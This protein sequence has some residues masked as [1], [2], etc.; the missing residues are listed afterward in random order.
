MGA[1]HESLKLPATSKGVSEKEALGPGAL[2][3]LI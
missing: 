3:R 2:K 1:N